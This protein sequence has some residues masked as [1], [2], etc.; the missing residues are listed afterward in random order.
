MQ[1]DSNEK[2]RVAIRI[3]LDKQKSKLERNIM[4]QFSTPYELA[5]E[6]I[7]YGVSLLEKPEDISFLDPAFGTGTFYSALTK[8]VPKEKIKIASG[9][10]IDAH[11]GLPAFKLW[12]ETKLDLKIENFLYAQAPKKKSDLYDF[13]ICNPPYVRHHHIS[14][15]NKVNLMRITIDNYRKP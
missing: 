8:T 10:E 11:Y 1:V 4:G 5:L 3:S 12:A 6:M 14:S 2:K 7:E 15:E 13:I 9:F